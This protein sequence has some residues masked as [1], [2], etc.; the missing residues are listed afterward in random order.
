MPPASSDPG[1]LRREYGRAELSERDLSPDPVSQFDRWFRDALNA[2]I[3]DANSM[4]LA[5]VAADGAPS[6]RMVLLK[7]FDARGFVFFTNYESRKARE[8]AASP[9]AELMFYWPAFERQVRIA[10]TVERVAEEESD[11]YF[12]TRPR[13]AQLAAWASPQSEVIPDRSD[14]EARM[15]AVSEQYARGDVP[16]PPHWGGYR[17]VPVALEFWQGRVNRLHDRLRY[18]RE[19]GGWRIER[20]AP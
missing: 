6:V 7:D 12:R 5:T 14:L 2:G 19:G 16:P 10:G 15:Q 17:L 11:A 20:L 8:L 13:E 9:R 3:T 18:V 1:D 4:A